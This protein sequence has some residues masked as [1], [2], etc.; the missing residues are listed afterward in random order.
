MHL[1]STVNGHLKYPLKTTF[2]QAGGGGFDDA[3]DA[4][5]EPGRR[6]PWSTNLH[7]N[8]G[9]QADHGPWL[10]QQCAASGGGGSNDAGDARRAAV[11]GVRALQ[12]LR[13]GQGGR[14]RQEGTGPN[15]EHKQWLR[16]MW[17]RAVG[18]RWGVKIESPWLTEPC[19]ASG[20]GGA[21]DAG[22]T[23]APRAA[24]ISRVSAL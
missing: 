15:V 19:A 17:A 2:N 24:V 18:Q 23:Q 6:V 22:D 14:G 12:D 21:D 20:G 4:H 3:G 8:A 5:L 13:E 16:E 10:I 11:I 1:K 7:S 9:P